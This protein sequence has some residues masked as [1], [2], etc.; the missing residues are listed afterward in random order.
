MP[1]D[2]PD[3]R[4]LELAA[5]VWK[6]RSPNE[7]ETEDAYRTALANHVQPKD[8]IESMEIRNKVGWDRFNDRQNLDMI[9][10]VGQPK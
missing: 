1:M 2:F 5:E 10:R 7:G 3:M 8:L 4:S 9:K 6:F